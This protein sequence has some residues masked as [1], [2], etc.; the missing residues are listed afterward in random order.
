M[1][2]RGLKKGLIVQA[3]CQRI[4]SA[5]LFHFGRGYKMEIVGDMPSISRSFARALDHEVSL[6]KGH[7]E[8]TNI[9][10]IF[11]IRQNRSFLINA[12][13]MRQNPNWG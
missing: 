10:R 12:P 4:K 8:P 5:P 9:V 11:D 7:V 13:Q 1:S 3:I 6:F 2:V